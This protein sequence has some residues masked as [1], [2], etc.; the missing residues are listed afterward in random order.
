MR[1]FILFFTFTFFSNFLSAQ[2]DREPIP[3]PDVT[4]EHS[5]PGNH[6]FGR[7]IDIQTNK[8]IEAASVQLFEKITNPSTGQAQDSLIRFMLSKTNGDFSF[9]KISLNKDLEIKI[10]AIGYAPYSK[11]FTIPVEVSKDSAINVQK[12]MGNII[13]SREH[14]KLAAITI[15]AQRPAMTLGID[16]KVFDVD[17]SITSK[18]G[19]AVDVMKN[20]PS[21]SVDVD[22]NIELRN[23]SPTIFIDGRP[24][25]LTL[26]QIAS[27]D[28]DRIEIISNPSAKYDASSSG[29]IINIILKK[30]RRHGLNG[31]ASLT[32]GTP[33]RY[34]GN[35]N[36]NLR[37]GKF[38]FFVNGNYSYSDDNSKANSLRENKNKGVITDYFDQN[39]NNERE[40]KFSS[41]RFGAD[42]FLDNRNTITLS[43]GFVVGR[44]KTYQYQE[45]QYKD[46]NKILEKYGTR[47]ADQGFQ[48]NRNNTQLLYT[49]KFP[50][51][52]ETLDVT[53]N[54][55][56]GN[57]KNYATILNSF[58]NPDGTQTGDLSHVQ[59]DG[60]NNN[61]QLTA[62]VDYVNPLGENKKLEA[63]L[64]S[65]TNNYESYF[66]SFSVDGNTETKLPLSNNYKYT[67]NVQAAYFTYTGILKN[68]GYQAGLRGEYSKFA[69]T[70]IDSARKFGYE[71]PS[72]LKNIWDVLFPS[73]Y[74]SRK[75]GENDEIQLNYARKVRR[76]NFWQLNPFFDINDPLNI[77]VGNPRLQPEFTNSLEFNYSKNFKNNSNFLGTISY[78]NTLGD[79]T[80]YSDTISAQQYQQLQDA[81][82]DPN[83]IVNTFINADNVNQVGVELTLQQKLAKDFT[84]TPSA[85]LGYRIV[86]AGGDSMNLSNEGF[87]WSA[88]FNADYKIS[89]KNESS[90]FNKL[91][92]Q[93]RADYHSPRVIPQ[94]KRLERFEADFAM[95]KD[96]FKDNKGTISFSINDIFNSQRYGVIYDTETFYQE[97]Y[98]RWRVRN[99]RLT[100]SYKFGDADFSLFKKNSS[101]NS[102]DNG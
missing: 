77:Q 57:V 2:I 7:I 38:N 89:T 27:D 79:I 4:I 99:F 32:W 71:Y 51:D 82:V 35:A 97:A 88:K 83:A 66:N 22:G 21:V 11:D 37:Q 15:V 60:A 8:G 19:T 59:N 20:I 25:I 48:F 26:D 84:I 47:T 46:S 102:D 30:N 41:I 54:A 14:E 42:Y 34:S 17:K 53:L 73:L 96:L 63:G 70:L 33:K 93:F 56:Y 100:F 24:T 95:R 62:K 49:H 44:F 69:G 13:M 101:S 16:K 40:R 87:N 64:R 3:E 36:L 76:P 74:L 75:L 9:D 52:G 61:N 98:S 91:A 6:I 50:K 5:K 94:G 72:S 1:Y 55:N 85:Y 92:F 18:G 31:I 43:Q 23:S 90:V 68:I 67:E 80:R 86:N 10:S 39:T 65:F 78:R 58:Y 45:Q 29:G 28:I 81:G 12:D